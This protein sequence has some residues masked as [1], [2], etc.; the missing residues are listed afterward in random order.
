MAWTMYDAAVS[1]ATDRARRYQ[2]I[3]FVYHYHQTWYVRS[4]SEGKPKNAILRC[5]VWPE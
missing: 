2:Q 5:K 1:Q 4:G 3:M